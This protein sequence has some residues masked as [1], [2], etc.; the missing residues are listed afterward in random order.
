MLVT[1]YTED[2]FGKINLSRFLVLDVGKKAVYPLFI[3]IEIRY[4]KMEPG[5]EKRPLFIVGDF[6]ANMLV[7]T[8]AAMATA[9]LIGG[10]LGM[11]AG[12]VAGMVVGAVIGLVSALSGLMVLLGA[13]E[14]LAP[15]M[16]SGMLGGMWGG[17]WPLS[18]D[19]AARWGVGIGLVVI[20]LIYGMNTILTRR[21]T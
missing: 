6:L 18:V 11:I 19:A 1:R 14:V 12:A 5:V 2:A 10:S 9:W 17:M 7:A 3:L 16:I 13:F 15:A 4:R 8:L 20:V 21:R